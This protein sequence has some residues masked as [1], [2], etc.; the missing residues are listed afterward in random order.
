[1]KRNKI[2]IMAAS[3]II[4]VAAAAV[5]QE[6]SFH[7][8]MDYTTFGLGQQ[9]GNIQKQGAD[10]FDWTDPAAEYGSFYNGRTE[11]NCFFTAANL[12]FN[13]GVRMDSSLGE[14]YACNKDSSDNLDD[15]GVNMPRASTMFHQGN[16]R[17]SFWQDQIILHAGKYE[18]WSDGF[19][20]DGWALGGQPMHF[21]GFRGTGTH[22]TGVEWVPNMGVFGGKLVGF[23]MIVGVPLLPPSDSYDWQEANGGGIIFRKVKIMAQYKWLRPNITFNVGFRPGTYYDGMHESAKNYELSHGSNYTHNF[24]SAAFLQVDL[25]SLVPGF[26]FNASYEARWREADYVGIRDDDSEYDTSKNTSSHYLGISGHTELVPGWVF[27]FENRIYYAADH[28]I[29]VN[30][31]TFFEQLGINAMHKI[32]GTSYNIG[33]NLNGQLGW[34]ARGTVYND[35]G[36]IGDDGY[37]CD[38]SFCSEWMQTA[39]M[40]EAGEPGHYYGIYAYPYFQKDFANGFF[41]TGVEMQYTYFSS[42]TD[43]QAFTY[44]VP[45]ALCFWY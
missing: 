10:D 38:F 17:A 35:N 15:D 26:K 4:G 5:A 24:F 37:S 28:Y 21:L 45:F 19:I 9:I 36:R 42:K 31:R 20:Y 7:G 22:F 23:R 30:E 34:D 27:N 11:I 12:A 18:E 1:M 2:L 16:M 32:P 44:R 6:A 40:P 8:Y 13:V 3:L 14:W 29:R 43:T 41:R 39:R 25:P 33:C